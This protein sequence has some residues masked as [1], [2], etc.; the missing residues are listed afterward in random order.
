VRNPFFLTMRS[1]RTNDL[2]RGRV[3]RE[4]MAGHIYVLSNQTY[5]GEMYKLGISQNVASVFQ[6]RERSQIKFISDRIEK[7]NEV[8]KQVKDELKMK[9]IKNIS[10]HQ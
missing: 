8:E 2:K 3:V 7:S 9:Q 10:K 5:E 6:G 1:K 4:E